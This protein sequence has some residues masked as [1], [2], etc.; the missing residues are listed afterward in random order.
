[1]ESTVKIT[2]YTTFITEP[3]IQFGVDAATI[4]GKEKR[5]LSTL[6]T[7]DLIVYEGENT[8]VR[9]VVYVIENAKVT[10]SAIL[11]TSTN[12]VLTESTTFYKERYPNIDASDSEVYILNDEETFGI[13]LSVDA[14]L[15]YN[16]QYVPYKKGG[17]KDLNMNLKIQKL[18]KGLKLH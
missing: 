2:P 16:A 14:D 11:F 4:K 5:K 17:R 6:S 3:I 12:A 7:A 18:L 15:G 8:N 9:Y 13:I 1:V 10:G